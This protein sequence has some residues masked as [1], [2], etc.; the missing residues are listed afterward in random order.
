MLPWG[1]CQPYPGILDMRCRTRCGKNRVERTQFE[2]SFTGLCWQDKYWLSDSI[3]QRC[4][5]SRF[6]SRQVLAEALSSL[7]V[8]S[9]ENAQG[10]A[11]QRE[12]TRVVNIPAL[13]VN[14]L[15]SL[16]SIDTSQQINHKGAWERS[17]PLE[18]KWF[19]I[20]TMEMW[21][22]W[23]SSRYNYFYEL[24]LTEGYNGLN[25][26]LPSQIHVESLTPST[27]ECDLFWKYSLDRGKWGQ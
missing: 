8:S 23:E 5:R 1:R 19:G 16:A 2:C 17:L 3:I 21:P 25:C 7:M 18:R 14:S 13:H 6:R 15:V 24:P 20:L 26:D 4:D 12:E 10:L 11:V 22:L 27:W 9:F